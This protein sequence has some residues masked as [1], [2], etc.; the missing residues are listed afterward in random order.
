MKQSEN[1]PPFMR[2]LFN[3]AVFIVSL[4]SVSNLMSLLFQASTEDVTTT[5]S[6]L[7]VGYAFVSVVTV[8]VLARAI[9][10]LD[11]RAG[12]IRKRVELFE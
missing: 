3:A 9:Y 1:A 4:L 5:E 11:K 2:F 6:L 10:Q 7:L 8:A 12:R